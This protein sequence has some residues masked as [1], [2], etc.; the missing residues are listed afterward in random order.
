MVEEERA[1]QVN[2]GLALQEFMDLVAAKM[3]QGEEQKK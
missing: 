3:L 2:E 1:N